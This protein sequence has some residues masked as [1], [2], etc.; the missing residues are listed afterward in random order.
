MYATPFMLG[1]QFAQNDLPYYDSSQMT[2][3]KSLMCEWS[4]PRLVFFLNEI[5][6]IEMD[7]QRVI[8][9]ALAFRPP[10]TSPTTFKNDLTQGSPRLEPVACTI[11][12]LQL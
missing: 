2:R 11:N 8:V 7:F 12:I 5:K 9:G 6:E 4:P 3:V 1:C 10:G